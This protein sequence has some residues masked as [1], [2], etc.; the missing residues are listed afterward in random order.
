MKFLI[1]CFAKFSLNFAKFKI[2]LSK[3]C[4]WQN[5]DKI[6]LKSTKLK[7]LR[8]FRKIMKTKILQPPSYTICRLLLTLPSC[9]LEDSSMRC[10]NATLR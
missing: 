5:F 2:I 7:M 6:I 3:F 4:V 8:K 9:L 1:L 10:G